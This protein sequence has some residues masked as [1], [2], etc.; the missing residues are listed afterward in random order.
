VKER[1]TGILR[2]E[3]FVEGDEGGLSLSLIAAFAETEEVRNRSGRTRRGLREG[4]RGEES[5]AVAQPLEE[6]DGRVSEPV[7]GLLLE[8]PGG[9]GP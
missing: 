4:L 5:G 3:L 9:N 2:E 1:V 7:R 8:F 6:E